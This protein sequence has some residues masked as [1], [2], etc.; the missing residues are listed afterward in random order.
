MI[1]NQRI[2]HTIGLKKR[3]KRHWK[4]AGTNWSR[5]IN[6]S[7]YGDIATLHF[8][9]E[10]AGTFYITGYD[11][12]GESPL[13]VRDF[14]QQIHGQRFH[15]EFRHRK[16]RVLKRLR[17]VLR[18]ETDYGHVL[19]GPGWEKLKHC[20]DFTNGK[21]VVLTNMMGNNF[22]VLVFGDDGYEINHENLP[23]TKV[24][25]DTAVKKEIQKDLRMRH[26]CN[27]KGHSMVHEDEEAVFYQTLC[28][29]VKNKGSLIV[30]GK[31][32]YRLELYWE[33]YNDDPS[34]VNDMK[35]IGNWRRIS[36]HCMFG[37]NKTIRLKYLTYMLDKRV[38][39][40]IE[41]Y[42]LVDSERFLI[43]GYDA[44]LEDLGIKDGSILF[45]RFR[46][47]GKSFDEGL[48]P[49]MSNQDVLS[50]LHY[51][52]IYKEMEVY[53]EKNSMEV[54]LG[55]G[56]GVVIEEVVEDDEVKEASETRNNGKQL[57]SVTEN[58]VQT[59]TEPLTSPW[60][61][62]SLSDYDIS[63]HPPWSSKSMNE[64]RNK[65][66]SEEFQFRKLLFDIDLT[67]G[68]DFSHE[69]LDMKNKYP[70]HGEDEAEENAELFN[71]QD[72]LLEH[73]PF[74]KETVVIVDGDAPLLAVDAPV[75]PPVIDLEEQLE[76]PNKRRK[77][78]P[79]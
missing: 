4:L 36:R 30:Y 33:F 6:R 41:W 45:S 40:T 15:I 25:L 46:I 53:V 23:R 12:H 27:W 78:N 77:L 32:S 24:I 20:F 16:H 68:L 34:R 60:S 17:L 39:K 3:N 43:N 10:G 64:K 76:R 63:D 1:N 50:V 26:F 38:V 5:F 75:V 28:H 66:L 73:V 44:M 67:F 71:E 8:I 22:R 35:L 56:K 18:T 70:Y 52:S 31:K 49:L 47:P 55:T 57:L 21:R 69:T 54:V 72:H 7:G 48:V 29:H 19:Y 14:I 62:E 74:L 51:V 42:D 13:L 37:K 79:A 9:W 65:R 11:E 59:K 61:F 58:D 2:R